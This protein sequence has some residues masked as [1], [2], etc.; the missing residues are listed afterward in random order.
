MEGFMGR[1]IG[2]R[3]IYCRVPVGR[4]EKHGWMNGQV[5]GT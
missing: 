3:N 2:S 5:V 1:P 4:S